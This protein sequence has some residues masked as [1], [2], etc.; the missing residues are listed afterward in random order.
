MAASGGASRLTGALL[1]LLLTGGG[2]FPI[3]HN[4]DARIEAEIKARLVAEKTA[5]LTRL[6]VLS[7]GGTVYLTGTV[8]SE[9]QR[10]QAEGLTKSVSGV[11]HVVNAL[12]VR[13]VP[14]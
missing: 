3:N 4:E 8:Q 9:V 6:G 14:D 11:R 12:E 13:T 1:V 2:C 7:N 5:N 10:A